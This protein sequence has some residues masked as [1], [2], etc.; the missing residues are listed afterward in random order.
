MAENKVVLE[1]NDMIAE[2]VTES[3]LSVDNS[4]GAKNILMPK[5]VLLPLLVRL[6]FCLPLLA[7]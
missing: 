7:L 1:K 4:S 6:F 3:S 2:T 5:I